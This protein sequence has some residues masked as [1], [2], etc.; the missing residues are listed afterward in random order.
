MTTLVT[1]RR[2]LQLISMSNQAGR[3]TSKRL[4]AVADYEQDDDFQ[5]VRKSKRVKTE[6]ANELEPVKNSGRGR[7]RPAA[8]ARV[9]KDSAPASSVVEEAVTATATETAKTKPT[10]KST[11]RKASVD[12]SNEEP[13]LK[14]AKRGTRRSARV[15]VAS[16]SLPSQPQKSD[17]PIYATVSGEKLDEEVP[18]TN[19][20]PKKR[21]VPNWDESPQHEA[22]IAAAKIALPMSDTPVINRN[23]AMRKKGNGNRRSSLG[24]RGRRASSLIDSGQTAIP[25]REVDP[26]GFYKHIEA[27]GLTEPRRM[28]QLLTWCGERALAE[29]PPHGTPNAILGARAIQ[30]QLLKDFAARSEFSDWFSRDDDV[31]K[32][33]VQPPLFVENET[34]LIV[35]PDFNLLDLEEGKIRSY[36]A[37]EGVS[38][39]AIRSQTGS[40]LRAIQSSLEFHIDQLPDNVHKLEQRVL[41]AGEEAEKVLSISA[42][43]LRQREEREKT[44]AGTKQM[45]VMEVLRRLGN[46]VPEVAEAVMSGKLGIA[47]DAI[48]YGKLE[49]PSTFGLIDW[50][51]RCRLHVR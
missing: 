45:P 12:A 41:V 2:P 33:P 14:I 51:V 32:V 40:R 25:H 44:R 6:K 38:F 30:D 31:P 8:K 48:V 18:Q 5:F 16:T 42:L 27:D 47:A 10:R 24:M 34:D 11:R 49:L 22:P 37:D 35:L 46:I 26:A 15:S 4:A 17:I 28:K 19:G 7:G 13:P 9:T 1:T 21:V 29:K 36:L 43:R 50:T 23:K 20:S 3:R 39:E